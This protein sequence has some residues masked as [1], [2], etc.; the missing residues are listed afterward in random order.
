MKVKWHELGETTHAESI[1]NKKVLLRERKRHT[2]RRVAS[3]RYAALSNPDLVGGG[4]PSRPGQGGV[5]PTHHP[6][7]VGGG[8]PGIPTPTIQ[9]WSGG[10]PHPDLAWGGTLGTPQTGMEYPP[11][12]DG[13][14]PLD[15]G[16]GTPHLDLGW[17][18]PYLDLGWGTPLPRPGMGYP[19]YL[20]L[21]WGTPL[22]R[23]EMGYLPTQTWDWVPPPHKCGQTENITSRH[24]LDAGGNY[25]VF[26]FVCFLLL[27]T[28]CT[29]KLQPVRLSITLT[30]WTLGAQ[31]KNKSERICLKLCNYRVWDEFT[32]LIE[33]TGSESK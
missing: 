6:D 7:L 27:W 15:L 24:P 1:F 14:L 21:R 22:P 19:P 16:W 31:Q 13:V 12:W 30:G 8:T 28:V 9:T 4:T 2:A 29:N 20:D 3:T 23:P 10:L 25:K 32:W 33:R 5:P 11:T 26:C 17:V 18:P